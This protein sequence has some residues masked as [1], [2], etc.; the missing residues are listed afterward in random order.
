[1]SAWSVGALCCHPDALQLSPS[2]EDDSASSP[3]RTSTSSSSSTSPPARVASQHEQNSAIL[4]TL[5]DFERE[6]G[7]DLPHSSPLV[8]AM[9]D[10]SGH[11]GSSD[12]SSDIENLLD[13]AV[14][15]ANP[16]IVPDTRGSTDSL[17]RRRPL[18]DEPEEMDET[19]EHRSPVA[20]G[21]GAKKPRRPS[22]LAVITRGLAGRKGSPAPSSS[23]RGGEAK[24]T[25]AQKSELLLG[26]RSSRT[27]D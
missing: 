22:A 15:S 8:R 10:S 14:D 21:S 19:D 5:A 9:S 24:P 26:P 13:S 12:L 16:R 25:D 4:A 2:A 17:P 11:S 27:R 23:G 6:H 20:A 1:M 18:V 3:F 7:H